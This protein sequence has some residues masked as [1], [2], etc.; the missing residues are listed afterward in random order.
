MMIQNLFK[1]FFNILKQ[2]KHEYIF[3]FN[4]NGSNKFS[5]FGKVYQC[6]KCGY[7]TI[8]T[9]NSDSE[10]IIKNEKCYD[11]KIKRRTKNREI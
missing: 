7:L 11:K 10:S 9:V 8:S 5:N 1:H 6:K 2:N 3:S 4:I